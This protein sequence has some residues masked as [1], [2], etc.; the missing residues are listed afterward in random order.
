MKHT[1]SRGFSIIEVMVG[2]FIFSMG[3]LAVYAVLQSSVNANSYNRNALVASNI[4][5]E[6]IELLRNIRDTNYSKYQIWNLSNPD[7][8][9]S[10]LIIPGIYMIQNNFDGA[11]FSVDMRSGPTLPSSPSIE[12]LEAYQLCLQETQYVYCDEADTEA[13]KVPFYS[14]LEIQT[15]ID[16]TGNTVENAYKVHARVF[17]NMRGMHEYT[18]ST[19]IADW[20]RL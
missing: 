1:F 5:R 6:N 17:W 9:S 12:E 19:V 16:E 11:N 15:L 3:L 14:Y 8:L 2:I 18:I 13:K 20:L 7:N 10:D 4:A